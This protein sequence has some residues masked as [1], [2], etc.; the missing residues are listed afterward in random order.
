MS[1]APKFDL[2]RIR[3]GDAMGKF[4]RDEITLPKNIF[5]DTVKAD[6]PASQ[7]TETPEIAETDEI[8]NQKTETPEIAETDEIANQ[9]T[10]TPVIAKIDEIANQKTETPVIAKA[11]QIAHQKRQLSSEEQKKITESA[12]EIQVLLEPLQAT[13][14][15]KSDYEKQVFVN[16]FREEIRKNYRVQEILTAGGIELIEIVCQP[17]GI[18]IEMG[19]KW[20]ETAKHY[21]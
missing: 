8:A 10:E 16:K 12:K 2:S 15:T 19:Q 7:K 20:L 11:H 6:K 5:S 18:P 14:P 17:L 4:K 1:E 3:V 21:R 9:K 13:F